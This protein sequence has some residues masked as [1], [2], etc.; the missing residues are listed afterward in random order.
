MSDKVDEIFENLIE[1]VITDEDVKKHLVSIA[2]EKLTLRIL[3]RGI[4]KVNADN[5]GTTREELTRALG[6]AFVVLGE[7]LSGS[8]IIIEC[9]PLRRALSTLHPVLWERASLAF[10]AS[11]YANAFSHTGRAMQWRHATHV[12]G[13]PI[14]HESKT[15]SAA[16]INSRR[17]ALSLSSASHRA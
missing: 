2:K 7:S 4:R 11:R 12:G 15:L 13:L 16:S 6:D 10:F 3:A 17:A 1:D 5:I 14:A 8:I 9:R